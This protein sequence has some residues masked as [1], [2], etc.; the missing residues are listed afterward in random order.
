MKILNIDKFLSEK[1]SRRSENDALLI[2]VK[3][4]ERRKNIP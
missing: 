4:L 3:Q 1:I 2:E